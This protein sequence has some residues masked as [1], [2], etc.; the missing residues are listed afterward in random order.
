MQQISS[1]LTFSDFYDIAV[2]GNQNWK[3]YFSHKE[4]AMNAYDY[5][6]EY[7]ISLK[8]KKLTN[9]MKTLLDLLITD[10]TDETK[11]WKSC[12]QEIK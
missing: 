8:K 10:N 1:K 7:N 4:I 9:T 3:G 6:C 11:Y 2:Y 5:L 12:I